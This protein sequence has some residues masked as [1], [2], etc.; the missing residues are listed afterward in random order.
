MRG[1]SIFLLFSH[2]LTD[3]QIDELKSAGIDNFEYMPHSLQNL[4]SGVLPD[5]ESLQ[6]YIKPVLKWL[7]AKAKKGDWVLVQGDFGAVCLI[8]D[9]CFKRDFV[10]VYATTKRNTVEKMENGKLIKISQ[11]EHVRFR[12]YERL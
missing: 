5:I 7:D 6:D 11:F 2:K 12:K 8:V 10:P 3:R 4:W 9:F 1:S